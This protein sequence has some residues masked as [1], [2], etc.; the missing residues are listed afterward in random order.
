MMSLML[1]V[2]K[3]YLISGSRVLE[4]EKIVLCR[5]EMYLKSRKRWKEKIE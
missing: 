2:S 3:G 5:L 1:L 4:R